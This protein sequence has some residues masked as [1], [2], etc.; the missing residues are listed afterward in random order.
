MAQKMTN[1]PVY[2]AIAQA[3]FNPILSLDS[4]LPGIQE[5]LRKMGYEDYKRTFVT[6]FNLALAAPAE[7]A[8]PQPPTQHVSR[9]AFANMEGTRGFILEPGALS[10]QATDY[11]TFK[12]FAGSL[13]N[14]LRLLHDAVTISYSERVGIR[15]L[16]AVFPRSDEKLAQY[17]AP[18]VMGLTGKLEG[19]LAHSFSETMTQTKA[20]TIVSRTVI[21]NGAVG[22]P[23]DLVPFGLKVAERFTGLSGLHATV[24]TDGYYQA[25]EK[26]D[27][28][29]LETRLRSL[30]D[31]I[32]TSF[33]ATVTKHA[34]SA[35][36]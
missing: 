15:Y 4:Y 19:D 6:S 12:T 31:E 8:P 24:D 1:A 14:G 7:A 2:F 28:K 10:F 3:R 21:E 18:E 16:D 33:R 5:S 20:G 25:R 23:P 11:D 36:E 26:F 29:G 34:L 22:F 35:W 13:L 17:L 32:W 27:L 30:H 9:Y